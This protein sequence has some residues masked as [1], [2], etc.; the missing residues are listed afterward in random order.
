[1]QEELS[2]NEDKTE[3]IDQVT[4]LVQSVKG[5]EKDDDLAEINVNF[6]NALEETKKDNREEEK[7]EERPRRN[8]KRTGLDA[9]ING[10]EFDSS[11]EEQDNSNNKIDR[12]FKGVMLAE[13]YTDEEN[14]D[15]WIMSEKLDG[16]RC[17]WNGK[18][19]KTRNNNTFY[20]PAF[21]TKDFP[22]QILDGEL[23][24]ERGEFQ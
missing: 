14:I 5:D 18:T 19:M 15:G 16:V 11:E 4:E 20:P 22:D 24:M 8:L 1:M 12:R 13:K 7:K 3:E 17:V 21:F 2:Q 6:I 10:D 9:Y 23:W